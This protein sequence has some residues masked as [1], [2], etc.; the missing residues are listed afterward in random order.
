MLS[1]K[2]AKIRMKEHC[3]QISGEVTSTA[4]LTGSQTKCKK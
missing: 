3:M 4:E 2:V 1:V